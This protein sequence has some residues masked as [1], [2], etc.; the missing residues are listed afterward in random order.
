[1]EFKEKLR[2]DAEYIY[3]YAIDR[4]LPDRAV[5]DAL[6][7]MAMPKGKLILISVGKAGWRMA[8]CAFNILGDKVH[9]GAVITK[10]GH[11]EGEIGKLRIFEAAHPIPDENGISATEYVLSLTE[12]LCED[13][14][15][16]FLVSG[17]GS[18]LFESPV[19]SLSELRSLTDALLSSGASIGEI[20]AVR[21]HISRVKGGR[22]ALHVSPA[23]IFA[24]L[25]SDV[26]G[27]APD[28]IASGP[29]S[30][31]S[32]T[33]AD[34]ADIVKRYGLS[35]PEHLMTQ[36]MCE[37]PK[38]IFGTEIRVGGSVDELC[39][40]A[41]SAAE[42]LG[43]KTSFL[44]SAVTSEARAHGEYLAELAIKN[45]D[46]DIPLAIITGGETVVKLKGS[47]MGGRNQETVLS[48]AMK[49]DGVGNIAI[50]SVGSDG[51]DGP[52]DAAGGYADSDTA[53]M[54]DRAGVDFKAALENNDSYNALK[55][56]NALVFTGPTGTNVNDLAFALI[57]PI[58]ERT[59]RKYANL[60]IILNRC[61]EGKFKPQIGKKKDGEGD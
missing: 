20:N 21:K 11:S 47:G 45:V 26:L 1:M 46:T 15:V 14:A 19:C 28:T 6:K 60:E 32:T 4:C 8:K 53:G 58:C 54:M 27:N 38:E 22:F 39:R 50:V 9:S 10:Y 61:A 35:I 48:A 5:T 43:Y 2:S 40:A 24:V 29:V 31:D 18:A 25:L 23:R 41:V 56:V 52:T 3:T 7:E 37:T 55:S 12:G 44:S 49:I 13:D 17:G 42:S 33:V 30:P 16:L 57:R 36:L 51:T 34:V 59:V